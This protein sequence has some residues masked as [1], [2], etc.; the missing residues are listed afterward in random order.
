ML[1]MIGI[2]HKRAGLD[3]REKLSLNESECGLAL[4]YL[5]RQE[6]VS[7][8]FLVSTCNRTELYLICISTLDPEVH[9]NNIFREIKKVDA[10]SLVAQCY[11]KAGE[12]AIRHLF[13]VAAGLDSM[14][15]G[16]S[17]ILGQLK[18]AHLRARSVGTHGF[19]S[20]SLCERAL[21][22][23]KKV[24]AETMIGRNPVSFG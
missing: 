20:H 24:Q 9:F 5:S 17:E 7:E 11:K 18:A 21:A 3:G 12:E 22:A 16:E 8:S 6:K 13:A 14:V 2:N 23:G 15:L 19:Y 4:E 10:S 1:A